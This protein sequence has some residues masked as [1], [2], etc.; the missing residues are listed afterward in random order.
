MPSG[1]DFLYAGAISGTSV[2]GLD[3]AV[4]RVRGE[5]VS[6]VARKTHPFPAPLRQQLIDLGQGEG[7]N[8]DAAGA[9]D[10]ALGDFIG[11]C[12]N[13][14]I[15]DNQLSRRDIRAI[16]S[17]GQTVRHRPG[18]AESDTPF[19]LQIGDPN[20][21]AEQTGLTT[22]A[23]FRRRDLAAG[24]EGA[25]LA[26][27]FHEAIFG[28]AGEYRVALNIGGISNITL[29]PGPSRQADDADA[30]S[31]L[32]GFDTGPG[33]ALMDAWSQTHLGAAFD[34][35]G[36]WAS[37]GQ[38]NDDLLQALL[39]DPYLSR[40]PPKS[41]GKERYNLPWLKQRLPAPPYRAEDVQRTLL[42]YT[43]VSI[44][45]AI[46]QSAAPC[47]RIIVCGGGRLNPVLLQ[48]LQALCSASVETA[49]AHGWDGD[50]IEAAAFAWLAHCRLE[51]RAANS[52]GV[53][54]ARGA[55]VLGAVYPG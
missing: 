8:L 49:E 46:H 9:A 37:R 48:R 10:A 31:R 13:R 32:L 28:L 1:A 11:Q 12:I 40:M 17:H 52:P 54:G 23:D 24:G 36:A 21:I 2:D 30:S 33:N 55:R 29:L 27:A 22:V 39:N 51:H 15:E 4:I 6:L 53:T 38:V 44:R 35:G 14:L 18:R 25:P 50:A 19:T 5:A 20:R 43:A 3:T 47:E 16:G 41:T 42:E 34:D 45:D 7:D 26:T